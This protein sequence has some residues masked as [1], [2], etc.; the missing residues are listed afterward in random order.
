M[1][2]TKEPI[3]FYDGDCGFCNTS[4]QFILNRRKRPFYFSALQSDHAKQRLGEKGIEIKLDTLYYLKN[5]RV[6]DRSSAALQIAKGLGGAYPLLM[7][8][9]IV[10]PFIRNWV[11][12]GIAKRRQRIRKGYCVRPTEEESQY[13]IN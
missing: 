11:Y 12:N 10:P 3:I 8:F 1:T 4:V 13:F 2:Q 9:Y 7:I 5:D 6:Y